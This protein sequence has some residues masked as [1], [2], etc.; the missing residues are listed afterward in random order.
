MIAK[1]FV[2]ENFREKSGNGNF[3]DKRGGASTTARYDSPSL[4]LGSVRV[5]TNASLERIV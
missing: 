1:R 5:A 3:T 4:F 2:W